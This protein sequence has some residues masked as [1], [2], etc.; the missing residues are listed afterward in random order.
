MG[1]LGAQVG[2]FRT[3]KDRALYRR[4]WQQ[5]PAQGWS[6]APLVIAATSLVVAGGLLYLSFVGIRLSR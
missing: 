2:I 4:Y 5:A 3:T 6:R 1:K